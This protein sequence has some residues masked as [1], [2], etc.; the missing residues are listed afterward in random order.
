M[1]IFHVF[2]LCKRYQIAQRVTNIA[3]Y[4]VS[5][6]ISNFSSTMPDTILKEFTKE[7]RFSL[8]PPPLPQ[9]T[10]CS[11]VKEDQICSKLTI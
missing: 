11:Y 3:T 2:K 5:F 9:S 7:V 1:G 8:A 10:F 4:I 6:T